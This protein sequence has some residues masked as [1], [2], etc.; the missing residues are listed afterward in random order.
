MGHF[1]AKSQL[2]GAQ[3]RRDNGLSKRR[4][5]DNVSVD[6][7]HEGDVGVVDAVAVVDARRQVEAVIEAVRR[8]EMK[9]EIFQVDQMTS[10]KH[11]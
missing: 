11:W 9:P 7:G 4:K 8:H 2:K 6:V 10:S 3:R 1:T 5:A